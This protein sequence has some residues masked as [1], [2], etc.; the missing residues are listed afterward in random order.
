MNARIFLAGL[1]ITALVTPALAH[2]FLQHASPGAGAVVTKAPQ[3]IALEFSEP[4]EP[5]FSGIT[6]SDAAGHD[7]AAAHAVIHGGSMHIALN[8][9]AAGRYRVA[10][11]AVSVDTHRTEGAYSFTVKP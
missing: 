6:V 9:L 2:A 5:T 4:L 8:P 11:R 10:W 3:E 1:A 7:M